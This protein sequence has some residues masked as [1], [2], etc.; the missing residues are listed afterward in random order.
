MQGLSSV[1]EDPSLYGQH[2]RTCFVAQDGNGRGGQG[3]KSVKKAGTSTL[4]HSWLC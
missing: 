2:L 4:Q 1:H 3:Y